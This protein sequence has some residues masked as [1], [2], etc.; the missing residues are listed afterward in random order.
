MFSAANFAGIGTDINRGLAVGKTT[1][2]VNG[3]WSQSLR[4]DPGNYVLLYEKIGEYGPDTLT[5][6]VAPPDD[7][8]VLPVWAPIANIPEPTSTGQ[9]IPKLKTQ[10]PANASHPKTENDCWTI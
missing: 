8:G 7:D 4:V 5:I 10:K 3:R 1:T 9:S 6:T 2:R